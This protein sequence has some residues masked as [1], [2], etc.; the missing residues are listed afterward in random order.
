M[1]PETVGAAVIFLVVVGVLAAAGVWLG[2]LVARW[3]DGRA[4]RDDE[5]PGGDERTDD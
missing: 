4:A 2:M 1:S 3:L 5:E